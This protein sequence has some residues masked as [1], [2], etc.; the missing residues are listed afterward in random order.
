MSWKNTDVLHRR[1]WLRPIKSDGPE[2]SVRTR[3]SVSEYTNEETGKS[4]S[5]IDSTLTIRDCSRRIELG[6]YCE[7]QQSGLEQLKA[8]DKLIG[9]LLVLNDHLKEQVNKHFP[10]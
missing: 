8:L 1:V 9:E 10:S 3:V 2:T 4:E 5:S 6:F 7:N